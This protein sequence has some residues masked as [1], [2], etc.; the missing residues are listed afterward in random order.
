MRTAPGAAIIALIIFL[1]GA[2]PALC[3]TIDPDLVLIGAGSDA[4]GKVLAE[5]DI[6]GDGRAD[7]FISGCGP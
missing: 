1:T 7:L 6:N 3:E 5:G 4:L 2:A